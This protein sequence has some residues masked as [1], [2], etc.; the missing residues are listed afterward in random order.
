MN[1]R[2][3]NN[4]ERASAL[5]TTPCWEP[6]EQHIGERCEEWM[7]MYRANGLEYY[8]HRETRRY[9][10]LDWEG[11][12]WRYREVDGML[13]PGDFEVEHARATFGYSTESHNG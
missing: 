2:E 7:W 5:S 3:N 10:I 8:K 1:H 13:V 11:I 6:L 9:L 12:A 4:Q